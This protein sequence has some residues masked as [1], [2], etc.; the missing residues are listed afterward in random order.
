MLGLLLYLIASVLA[1]IEALGHVARFHKV[2]FYSDV[3]C[4]DFA[5]IVCHDCKTIIWC[6]NLFDQPPQDEDAGE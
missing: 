2:E 4:E 1:R 5:D 6:R 3:H